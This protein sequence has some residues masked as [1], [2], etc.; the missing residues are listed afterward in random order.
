MQYRFGIQMNQLNDSLSLQSDDIEYWLNKGQL[1]LVKNKFKGITQ[2]GRGFE[3]SLTKSSDLKDLI[4][5]NKELIVTYNGQ[6]SGTEGYY[7]DQGNLPEDLL[8]LIS[9]KSNVKWS[10]PEISFITIQSGSGES[11]LKLTRSSTEGTTKTVYGTVVQ[12]DQI[13]NLLN[14]PFNKPKP[15]KPI[16]VV[17]DNSIVIFTDKTFIVDKIFIDYIRRPRQVSIKGNIDSELPEDLHYEIIQRAV[18]LFLN[19]TRQLK[20]RL[21]RETP[22]DKR[23]I[24]QDNE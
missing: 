19:N 24:E 2:T 12:S 18:D 1:D 9:Y 6:Y 15:S 3:Q 11:G 8:Y 23:Q 17:G 10:Y 13:Y 16:G 5:R 7:A 14:D 21:Q 20:S 22:T 4:E